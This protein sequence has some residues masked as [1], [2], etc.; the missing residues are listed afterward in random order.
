MQTASRLICKVFQHSPVF[1]IGGD[2]FAA[3]LRNEDLL[4]REALTDA[5]ERGMEESLA[6]SDNQWEQVHVAM[7]LAVYDEAQDRS[8]VDTMRRADKKMYA[9]KKNYKAARKA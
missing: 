2:E 4:N 5:F 8:A 7:G 6:A 3:V 9:N 1:R